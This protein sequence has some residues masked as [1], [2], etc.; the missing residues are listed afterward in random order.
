MKE[1]RKREER[2]GKEDEEISSRM[3]NREVAKFRVP[4][5]RYDMMEIG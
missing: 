2:W 5:S 3:V 4:S 1:M